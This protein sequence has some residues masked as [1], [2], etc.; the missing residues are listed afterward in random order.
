MYLDITEDELEQIYEEILTILGAHSID[1]DVT[2]K[3]VLIMLRRSQ[4]AFEKETS[5][6]QLQ[7][8]FSN[9]YG[10][11]AGLLQQNQIATMNFSI[12]QQI[13]DWFASMSR[14][15]GKIPWHKDYIILEQGRQIYDLSK[16]SSK[17]YPAGSRRIHRVMWVA[18]PETLNFSKYSTT[19]PN[20]DDILYSSNWNF[21]TN[22]LN[23]GASP[24]AFLGYSMDTIMLMQS[25]K[26]RSRILFSEFFHNLSGDILEI[27]PMPGVGVSSFPPGMKLF[28]YYWDESEVVLNGRNPNID[29]NSEASSE[30]GGSYGLPAGES[31]LIANPVDMKIDY[32][33]WSSLSPWAKTWIFDYTLARCKYIQGSKWR[34]I[35]KTI[36][37]GTDSYEIEFD[38][39]SLLSEAEN[40][41]EKLTNNLRDDLK[42]LNIAKLVEDKAN[43]AK[44][45]AS[46]SSKGGRVWFFGSF[47]LLL[48]LC[49]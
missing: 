17:P 48:F 29:I 46:V 16:E 33:M 23:Y 10:T 11:P 4:L 18:R 41:M 25:A 15:G 32:T 14:N 6:W 43:M 31:N 38:Y 26:E 42:E 13:S 30:I 9:V 5:I 34:T 37:T 40:E 24:L 44:N 35:K 47:L 1:V 20:G 3:E 8:Q 12:T 49:I 22:G 21:T 45:A 7:N 27:T 19:N 2:K 28:Y 36:G 39:Q